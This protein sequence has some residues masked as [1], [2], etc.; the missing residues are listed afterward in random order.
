MTNFIGRE[1]QTRLILENTNKNRSSL[2]ISEAGVGKSALLEYCSNQ[3]RAKR[4]L[5]QLSRTTP[6]GSFL[7]ELFSGLHELGLITNSESNIDEVWKEWKKKHSLNEDKARALLFMLEKNQDIVLV[8]DDVNSVTPS[9]RPWLEL[10][11]QTV[12][13]IA[14]VD[15]TALSKRGTKRFWKRFDEVKLDRLSKEESSKILELLISKY[16]IKADDPM[17]YKRKVLELAQGSPFELTRLVKYHSAESIVK[18]DELKS[19]SQ[20]FVERDV[21]GIAIAP[22]L[23]IVGAFVIAGRYI[24]RA[25]GDLDLY[26]LS[27]IGIGVMLVFGPF[28]RHALK[29]RSS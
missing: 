22:I 13:V 25:Q 16:S 1:A 2:I 7:K 28:L 10:I 14:A 4:S 20:S 18:T 3:I 21:K 9:N 12:T 6:F 17:I 26:V 8:I 5:V 11:V 29:P 15:L 24:A 19:Y 27:G 23:L